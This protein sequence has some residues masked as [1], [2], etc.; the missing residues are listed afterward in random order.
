MTFFNKKEEVLDVQLTAEGRRQLSLGT[1]KP[2]YYAFYDDD[3]LY[4]SSYAFFQETQNQAQERILDNTIYPKTN[5]RFKGAIKKGH[6]NYNKNDVKNEENIEIDIHL[7]ESPFFTSLGSYDSMT[8]DAPYFEISLLTDN[9]NP[10]T[11]GSSTGPVLFAHVSS[12]GDAGSVATISGGT[13]VDIVPQINLT[14]SYKYFYD[15]SSNTAYYREDPIL[16]E[17]VERNTQFINFTDN[18]EVEISEIDETKINQPKFF[19]VED[20]APKTPQEQTEYRL[21][22]QRIENDMQNLVNESLEVLLDEEAKPLFPPELFTK[23]AIE[24]KNKTNC[25]EPK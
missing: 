24:G 15:V 8:N 21:K 9:I 12:S 10:L 19:I 6:G 4:D 7:K 2:M 1:L 11:T 16:L 18:F 14:A 17:I 20:E 5:A 13:V 25:E 3:V 22:I 23:R